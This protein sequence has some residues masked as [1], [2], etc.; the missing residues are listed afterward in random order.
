MVLSSRKYSEHE[1]LDTYRSQMINNEMTISIEKAF[2]DDS[3]NDQ[4]LA[5]LRNIDD[6]PEF[7]SIEKKRM[8]KFVKDGNLV[9]ESFYQGGELK[10]FVNGPQ[11]ASIFLDHTEY[12]LLNEKIVPVL[13]VIIAG[14][15]VIVPAAT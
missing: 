1:L 14:L 7:E 5:L 2:V 15:L 10:T 9:C 8:G 6:L 3:N 4:F 11:K 13:V 12:K